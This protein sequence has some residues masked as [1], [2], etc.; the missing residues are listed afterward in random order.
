MLE[1]DGEGL[2]RFRSMVAFF[3]FESYGSMLEYQRNKIKEKV[4]DKFTDCSQY[5]R[6]RVV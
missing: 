1:Q 5:L 3:L 4:F 2:A 6:F